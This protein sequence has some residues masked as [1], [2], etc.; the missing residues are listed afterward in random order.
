MLA[1]RFGTVARI[2]AVLGVVLVVA[3]LA[4]VGYGYFKPQPDL[5]VVDTY[6]TGY[7]DANLA[8]VE[9]TVDSDVAETL[10]ATQSIFAYTAKNAVAGQVK[11]WRVKNVSRN[12]YV[13]QSTIDVA[14]T[15]T[16]NRTFTVQF[17]VLNLS[18]TTG[19]RI[20]SVIDAANPTAPSGAPGSTGPAKAVD[21]SGM[22]LPAGHGGGGS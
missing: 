22:A 18:K 17:D 3:V 20:R 14:V 13:G 15:T 2:G 9:A 4:W 8:L 16:K 19:Y 11:S 10:P 5:K 12:E 6:L 7:R 1:G 21:P